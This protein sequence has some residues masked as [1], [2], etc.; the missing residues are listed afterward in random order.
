MC[1]TP[2]T[3]VVAADASRNATWPAQNLCCLC[4][5]AFPW[6]D[7]QTTVH[8]TAAF[9]RATAWSSHW[10]TRLVW[11]CALND[12]TRW[13]WSSAMNLPTWNALPVLIVDTAMAGVNAHI[14]LCVSPV[15]QTQGSVP[16][17]RRKPLLGHS[18]SSPAHTLLRNRRQ[19]RVR[20][21]SGL[22]QCNRRHRDG[23]KQRRGHIHELHTELK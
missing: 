3:S 1:E 10:D 6:N 14:T 8:I 16:A 20:P 19:L 21:L 23:D 13:D 5:R 22:C 9:T 2:L 7:W 18:G 12:V 11:Q 17:W 4:E 15:S